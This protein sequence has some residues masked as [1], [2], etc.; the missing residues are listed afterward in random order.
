MTQGVIHGLISERCAGGRKNRRPSQSQRLAMRTL[1][2]L[3]RPP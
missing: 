3:C 2:R 1:R